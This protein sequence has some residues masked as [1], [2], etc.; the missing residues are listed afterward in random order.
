MGL[1]LTRWCHL[2]RGLLLLAS[3][4]NLCPVRDVN[5]LTLCLHRTL[6]HRP[7]DLVDRSGFG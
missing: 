6:A 5:A 1:G 3:L 2:G 7:L 4:R